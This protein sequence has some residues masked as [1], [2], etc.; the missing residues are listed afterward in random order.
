MEKTSP[1]PENST[2]LYQ[3]KLLSENSELERS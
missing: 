1:F 3:L 2:Y